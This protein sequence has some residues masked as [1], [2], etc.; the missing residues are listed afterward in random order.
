[1]GIGI[2]LESDF[3]DYY[4]SCF[5][6]SGLLTYKRFMKDSLPRGEALS[7]ISKFKVPVIE[8]SSVNNF[9]RF[10]DKLVVYTDPKLH[11]GQGKVILSRSEASLMHGN[12]L[13]SPFISGTNGVYLKYL[14]IGTRRFQ[15]TMQNPFDGKKCTM[16]DI[17]NI[18]ELKPELNFI[19]GLPIF[20]ID[21]IANN[22]LMMAIDFNEVQSLDK[23]RF[24]RFM[25]ASDIV[26]EVEKAL[27]SY[28]KS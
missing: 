24:Q 17:I 12:C 14:Q 21:Y 23:L 3:A 5:E 4:D 22:N 11:D 19:I 26:K 16:G 28:N 2:R 18:Q 7:L 13:A 6:S 10:Y 8:I 15:L 25:S 20:S 9:G 27:I 1:M